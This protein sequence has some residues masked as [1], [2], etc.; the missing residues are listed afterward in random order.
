MVDAD[1]D[2]NMTMPS[3]MPPWMGLV[4]SD[5][6]KTIQATLSEDL[7]EVKQE[8]SDIKNGQSDLMERVKKLE[9]GQKEKVAVRK[10]SHGVPQTLA[11]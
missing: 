8:I 3:E 1:E 4:M 6:R 2:V 10:H 5:V 11:T 9:E 7:K